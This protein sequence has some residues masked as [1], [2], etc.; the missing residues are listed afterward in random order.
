[1]P[2]TTGGEQQFPG[3]VRVYGDI[4]SNDRGIDK[5]A[6]TKTTADITLYVA[7]AGNDS[8]DGL[9]AGN[10]LLT[11]QAAIDKIPDNILHAVTINVGAGNFAA[12]AV[13]NKLIGGYLNQ[14][15]TYQ[16]T[17]TGAD[18]INYTPVGGGTGSGTAT[19]GTTS[20]LIDAGQAWAANE[21]RGKLVYVNSSWLFIRSNDATSLETIGISSS[22]MN[23]KA[24]VIQDLSTV[25]NTAQSYGTISSCIYLEN[26]HGHMG[27]YAAI[28]ISKFKTSGA[29]T[30][31][32]VYTAGAEAFLTYISALPS[33]SSFGF[34][35]YNNSGQ[36]GA[37][38]C[39]IVGGTNG[40]RIRYS[41]SI[42][43][44]PLG[45]I[46]AL[47]NVFTYGA[48]T[49]G[50]G[51]AFLTGYMSGAYL[52][53]DNCVTGFQIISNLSS[54]QITP[55]FASYNTTYGVW[56]SG[57]TIYFGAG[58]VINN[59]GIGVQVGTQPPPTGNQ[60]S[61]TTSAVNFTYAVN[62]SNNTLSGVYLSMN[63]FMRSTTLTGTGNGAY[64][65]Y[66]RYGSRAFI[67]SATTITGTLGDVKI[68]DVVNSYATDFATDTSYV[69][70]VGEATLVERKDSLVF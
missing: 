4:Y 31:H 33:G 70:D 3:P 36:V 21:L 10:A 68:G 22:T 19:G 34:A 30:T 61:Q 12:F 42:I 45:S 40:F 57:G 66:A 28:N 1:M 49:S 58:S 26:V 69:W 2:V 59:N 16:F 39:C 14:P 53:A 15:A 56:V 64:G 51:L 62:V 47:K 8:N 67:S 63:S 46:L 37:E 18:P 44:G 20:T 29:T 27:S 11:I 55:L 50:I 9:T 17:I 48:S 43:N 23:G 52:Y 54:I 6:I 38:N 13:R 60:N 65:I 24:Y 32:A 5:I 25:I 35:I 7:A 41:R